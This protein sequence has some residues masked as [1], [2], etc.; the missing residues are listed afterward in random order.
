[1]RKVCGDTGKARLVGLALSA[2]LKSHP[3][4]K[5]FVLCHVKRLREGLRMTQAE[6]AATYRVPVGTLRDWEQRRK[7]PDATARAYL[8]VIDRDPKVVAALL[9]AA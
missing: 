9:H 3:V 5:P 6:L 4:A 8:I 7:H 1:L 2:R